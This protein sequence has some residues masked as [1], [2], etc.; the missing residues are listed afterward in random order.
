MRRV[1]LDMVGAKPSMLLRNSK[2]KLARQRVR[3]ARNTKGR[4]KQVVSFRLLEGMGITPPPPPSQR[5]LHSAGHLPQVAHI[6]SHTPTPDWGLLA[7]FKRF[8]STWTIQFCLYSPAF[9]H[10]TM[11]VLSG[12]EREK[13]NERPAY[14]PHSVNLA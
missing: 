2:L 12:E 5:R 4:Q 7:C 13:I 1:E 9:I 10:V 3:A 8:L 6:P 11:A 14:T